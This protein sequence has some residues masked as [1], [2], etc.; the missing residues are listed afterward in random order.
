MS[1]ITSFLISYLRFMMKFLIVFI[2]IV[3]MTSLAQKK[4]ELKRRY[5]GSYEGTI[6]GYKV[7]SS[8][9]IL[10]VSPALIQIEIGK[11]Q[12]EL[13]VGGNTLY[14]T[15]EIMF[16]AKKYYLMDVTVE[17]QLATER[18]LVYKTGKHLSR[19]GMYPQPVTELKKL[20]KRRSTK[21]S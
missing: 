1:L 3:P 8:Q 15:Y 10:D 21:G 17:G 18:I 20:K 19:D 6:P 14:G 13:T 2:L 7:E 4:I 12:V 16:E 9:D 11:N 5:L